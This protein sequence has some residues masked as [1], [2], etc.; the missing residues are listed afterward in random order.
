M[1]TQRQINLF[2]ALG[3]A[4][5]SETQIRKT[6]K[7]LVSKYQVSKSFTRWLEKCLEFKWREERRL[8]SIYLGD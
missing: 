4:I 1:L 5:E 8:T 7:E 3:H 6:H 2:K